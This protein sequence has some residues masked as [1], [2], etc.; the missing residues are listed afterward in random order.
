[1]VLFTLGTSEST[2]DSGSALALAG[3]LAD[4]SEKQ[5]GAGLVGFKDDIEYP[6]NTVGYA[7]KNTTPLFSVQWWADRNH[8]PS[9]Y[10]PAD[11]QE[12][13]SLVYPD[14]AK[15]L[16]QGQMPQV[17]NDL[18][19]NDPSKR[20]CYVADTGSGTFRLPD[21]N[22]MQ[23]SSIGSLFVRGGNGQIN[24][25]KVQGDAIR[26]I[27]GST[28][29]RFVP[30]AGTNTGAFI[31]GTAISQSWVG[32]TNV[33]AN[34]V[35][36]TFN[37]SLVVPTAEENRPVNV[38]GCWIIKLYGGISNTSDLDTSKL[39]QTY[40]ELST[41]ISGLEATQQEERF[42]IIYPN[43]GAADKP[44][45]ISIGSRYIMDNPFG[46]HHISCRAEVYINDLWG[47]SPW[48]SG[49]NAFSRGALANPLTSNDGTT[50]KIILQTAT[51]GV[52]GW[53]ANS[54][55]PMD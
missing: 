20:G 50:D 16:L 17:T 53:S 23:P 2:V 13:S 27:T 51:T 4:T 26:N 41:R 45:P 8:I 39:A 48:Q 18:W 22:G 44:A 47:T 25:G 30:T 3:S 31:N 34:G 10:F 42:A 35:N 55:S 11:G 9:G 33:V 12:L 15:A 54:G 52:A 28:V 37:A 5:K 1:M 19:L 24:D 7:L 38:T 32:V 21:Y 14:V 6:K 36:L 29:V 49:D 46:E 43:G 40:S